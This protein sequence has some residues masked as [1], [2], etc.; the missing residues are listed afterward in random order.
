MMMSGH[1][2]SSWMPG[3]VRLPRSESLAMDWIKVEVVTAD[4]S[5]TDQY[6]DMVPAEPVLVC[7]IFGNILDE[8][9]ER[10]DTRNV[11]S[12]VSHGCSTSSGPGIA[13]LPTGVRGT[14]GWFAAR[15][16]GPWAVG[17]GCGFRGRCT[18]VRRRTAETR[19]RI[20]HVGPFVGY[21]V[22]MQAVLRRRRGR[23]RS[24]RRGRSFGWLKLNNW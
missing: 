22:L 13:M 19:S 6:R 16:F 3:T 21:D 15:E 2:W 12:V 11:H 23:R 14:C 20:A 17:A 4:A 5:L 24:R 7:G 1:R 9:I 8:D 18:P 10:T